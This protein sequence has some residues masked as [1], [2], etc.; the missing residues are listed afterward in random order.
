M[1]YIVTI[2]ANNISHAFLVFGDSRGMAHRKLYNYFDEIDFKY[3]D[4]IDKIKVEL[5][6]FDGTGVINLEIMK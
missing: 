4:D 1:I 6:E 5:L 3:T 2:L